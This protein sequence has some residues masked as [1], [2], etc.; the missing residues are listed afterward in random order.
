MGNPT[1][2]RFLEA[3]AAVIESIPQHYANAG[4]PVPALDWRHFVE[5]LVAATGYE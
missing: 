3:L 2:P 1:L 5:M 4:Q